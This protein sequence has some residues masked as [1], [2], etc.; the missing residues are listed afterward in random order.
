MQMS[1][2]QDDTVQKALMNQNS[3]QGE[4]SVMHWV[5]CSQELIFQR[6]GLKFLNVINDVRIGGKK[7]SNKEV[8]PSSFVC[9]SHNCG[10][11]PTD[12]KVT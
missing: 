11:S 9:N 5:S 8:L 4:P 10:F 3:V 1:V 7:S 12:V 2:R 6:S